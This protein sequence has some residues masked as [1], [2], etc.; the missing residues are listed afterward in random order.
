MG[1]RKREEEHGGQDIW[2]AVPKATGE[3]KTNKLDEEE[4]F[5]SKLEAESCMGTRPELVW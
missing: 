2:P 3:M 1:H 5:C 4:A